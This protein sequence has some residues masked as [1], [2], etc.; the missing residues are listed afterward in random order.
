MWARAAVRDAWDFGRRSPNSVIR[1][2]AMILALGRDSA[3]HSKRVIR[4]APERTGH[5][6]CKPSPQIKCCGAIS[7]TYFIGQSAGG[8][9]L[10]SGVNK[11]R[12]ALPVVILLLWSPGAWAQSAQPRAAPPVVVS[13]APT[14]PSCPQNGAPQMRTFG[15]GALPTGVACATCAS[16]SATASRLQPVQTEVVTPSAPSAP[17]GCP[18]SSG[19]VRDD[20]A[21]GVMPNDPNK[22]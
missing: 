18:G 19:P 22:G 2:G 3:A 4:T 17:P 5:G 12:A 7:R 9:S 14:G 21:N 13:S 20:S 1:D 11:M 6:T 8:I 15:S 10:T 16:P